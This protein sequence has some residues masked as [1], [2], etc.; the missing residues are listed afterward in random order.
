M[1]ENLIGNELCI[2]TVIPAYNVA[3][4]IEK[5]IEQIDS[6]VSHI[7]IVDDK[8][9]QNSGFIALKVASLDQRVTVIFHESNLGVGGAV[10]TGYMR[11]LEFKSDIIV[12]IDGDG[13]MDPSDISELVQ[14]LISLDADYTKG[15][16]FFDS[17]VFTRMPRMRLLG[18]IVLSF[19]SKLSTG[20]WTIFDP[21]NGFTAITARTLKKLPMNKID[22]RYFFESDMLF[23]LNLLN[24]VVTDVPMP[25]IYG[26]EKSGLS[27][28]RSLFEFT[29]K[30]HRNF[31]KRIGYSYF[32]REFSLA[33][34]Q[35]IFGSG[36]L[37]FGFVLGCVNFISSK[38]NETSTPT[39]TL[40]LI[41]MA[42]LSGLQLLLSFFSYDMQRG[43]A[44]I[45][46]SR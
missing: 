17:N 21:N 10:K 46:G 14:P 28:T 4:H 32:L 19:L 43:T 1:C 45:T 33:S 9:P 7:I 34:L 36:L 23:R 13:Q 12:K 5:L 39:G 35:L 3:N 25:A 18:N 20:Y 37:I 27:V 30:H 6:S 26:D 41:A 42:V 31:F 24:A 29:Y 15:N 8:C 2:S 40:I 11:A 44:R 22:N 38:L 16:R